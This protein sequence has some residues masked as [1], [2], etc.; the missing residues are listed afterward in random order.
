MGTV[1]GTVVGT[2]VGSRGNRNGYNIG[3]V[4]GAVQWKVVGN[5]KPAARMIILSG[6][7]TFES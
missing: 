4:L 6:S 3:T 1:V 7:Q 5:Q 2:L